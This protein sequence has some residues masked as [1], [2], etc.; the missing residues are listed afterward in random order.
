L[1]DTTVLASRPET[2]QAASVLPVATV[3]RPGQLLGLPMSGTTRRIMTAMIKISST[4]NALRATPCTRPSPARSLTTS[5]VT[6]PA[7][8]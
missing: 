8:R 1:A 3:P 2:A 7:A 5:A 6:L 4:L